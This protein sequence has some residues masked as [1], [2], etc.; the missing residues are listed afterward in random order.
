[1]ILLEHLFIGCDALWSEGIEVYFGLIVELCC[2]FAVLNINFD[3]VG[4]KFEIFRFSVF[5]ELSLSL[6]QTVQV[7]LSIAFQS[8]ANKLVNVTDA[9]I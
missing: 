4:H 1:M 7:A 8:F 5:S 9:V 3:E 6:C 2:C